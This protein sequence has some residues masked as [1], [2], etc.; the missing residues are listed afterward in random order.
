MRAISDFEYEMQMA[1]MNRRLNR[2]IETVF[3]MPAE[4]YT[5]L[6]SRLAK[7][8]FA[9]G[10]SIT[11]LVPEVVETRLREKTREVAPAAGI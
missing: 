4:R 11:G 1:L 8:V 9:L 5:Y 6:S 7:E 3:M 2:S 10:G